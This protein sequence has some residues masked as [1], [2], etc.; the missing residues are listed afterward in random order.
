MRASSGRRRPASDRVFQLSALALAA[1]LLLRVVRYLPL[2]PPESL[3]AFLGNALI[4]AWLLF[5]FPLLWAPQHLVG[6]GLLL[7]FVLVFPRACL[8]RSEGTWRLRGWLH[9][10]VWTELALNHALF[11]LN[12]HLAALVAAG[13]LAFELDR[14]RGGRPPGAL[15]LAVLTGLCALWLLRSQVAVD[16]LAGAAFVALLLA[17]LRPLASRVGVRERRLVL[18]VGGVACQLGASLLPLLVPAHG[19]T[20]L[21]PGLAY[22]FCEVP[23]AGRLFAAIPEALSMRPWSLDGQ[24]GR[25]GYVA[26]YDLASLEPLR[27]LRFFSDAFYGRI[28]WLSCLDD[29]VAV[30]MTNVSVGGR[31]DQDHAMAF[32]LADPTAF[33]PD[34]FGGGV[35]H[36][37]AWDARR[38]ALFAVAEDG[39]EV[40]R[41]DRRT[42]E[43]KRVM[44]GVPRDLPVVSL[45]VGPD[46]IHAARD[47]LFVTEW[48]LGTHAYEASLATG[49]RVRAFPHRN[50][51]ALGISV[52]ADRG[53]LYVVG[54]WGM[55]VFDIATGALVARRRLGLL[56]RSPAIDAEHD[57][58]YVASTVEG[59][60]QVFDRD[61]LEPLGAIAVG[62]GPRIPH[63][64]DST[65]RLFSSSSLAHYVWDGEALA[66]R[67]RTER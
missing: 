18:L 46:S 3:D 43:R 53:R 35:G 39:P 42:G 8:V 47:S 13:W 32:P 19:G 4:F 60:I 29:T 67:F 2:A 17:T 49:E 48:F 52:D 40:M 34:L 55:E 59:R 16:A 63:Y 61:S 12:P 51:G 20:R 33:D 65:R 5:I 1:L 50:G 56:S 25:G 27:R 37:L 21:G 54:V 6:L 62:H 7:G 9:A 44:Q 23:A 24:H 31:Q 14:V 36:G 11:D 45:I 57:L 28:E 10:L 30:G 66:Q 64:S 41:L 26:E 15:P 38:D 22:S 58:V